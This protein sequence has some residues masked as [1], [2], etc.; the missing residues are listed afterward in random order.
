MQLLELD[1]IDLQLLAALQVDAS[2]PNQQRAERCGISPATALR[3][4]RRL[5]QL[6]LIE[7]TVALL[8]PERLADALGHGLTVIVEVTLDMQTEEQLGAFER[9]AVAHPSVQQVYR[10]SPGPDFVLIVAVRDMPSY[11]TLAQALFTQHR[12]VRHVKAYFSLKRSKFLPA[13]P[14]PGPQSREVGA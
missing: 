9:L 2:E 6:G 3:R 7:R 10:V 8:Q 14:L 4:V 1:A 12:H 5:E 11:Q 13:Q